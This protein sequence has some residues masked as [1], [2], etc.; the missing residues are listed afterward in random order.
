[1]AATQQ[2]ITKLSPGEATTEAA[3]ALAAA[4]LAG[5]SVSSSPQMVGRQRK[6]F[7]MTVASGGDAARALDA[8]RSLPDVTSSGTMGRSTA[9][10]YRRLI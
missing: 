5:F 8:L 3:G 10:I 6:V 4:N 2:R 7:L 9:Y 1:M